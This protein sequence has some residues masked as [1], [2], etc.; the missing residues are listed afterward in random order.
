MKISAKN[1][2][3]EG[4]W[5]SDRTVTVSNG[6]ITDITDGICGDI[7][8]EYLT[9]GLIDN[10]IHGGDGV[11][12]I[13]ADADNICG[14]LIKLAE[15]GVCGVVVS[16]YGKIDEIRGMLSV[17]REVKRRQKND[18]TGGAILIG[19]HIEGPFISPNRPGSFMSET[20][21]AP[22]ADALL[23]LIDGY[24]DIVT[25]MT[26]A[27][28]LTGNDE[29]IQELVSRGIKVLAGHT[30]CTYNQALSAFA[31]GVGATTHTFNACRPIHHREPGLIAAALTNGNV[32]CEMIC[33]L[34]HLHPGAIKLLYHC[35]G[36]KRLMVISDGVSTTNLPDGIYDENGVS[37]TVK[38]GESRLTN[39]GS[40]NGG[41]C[42]VSNSVKN[43]YGI[44]IP[45]ADIPY[46]T[47]VTPAEWLGS[48]NVI[49]IG[50]KAFMTAFGKDFENAF[51]IIK[52][53]IYRKDVKCR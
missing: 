35:K 22:S 53:R 25:E 4:V 36:A 28:E 19:A 12:V 7:L 6:I 18:E 29:V 52:N 1:L 48:E 3:S 46:M 34:V 33:D 39:V 32:Y 8:T 37:V 16:P 15:S 9:P 21:E 51:A 40:L 30:D 43:L 23:R 11:T 20:I 14:W 2:W 38:N 10:H 13:D 41:G 17:I 44:G 50:R 31:G 42:Y 24:E 5:L 49:R 26:V 27:P 45:S 47:A